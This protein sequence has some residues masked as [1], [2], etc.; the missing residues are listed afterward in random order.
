M[1]PSCLFDLWR[2][3][4]WCACA[5]PEGSLRRGSV[6]P[7][8]STPASLIPCVQKLSDQM[9]MR[10]IG[11]LCSFLFVVVAAVC[12]QGTFQY[13]NWLIRRTDFKIWLAYRRQD[14]W[15]QRTKS[16]GSEE[17]LK[18]WRWVESSCVSSIQTW[19]LCSLFI[20]RIANS[21]LPL[22][23]IVFNCSFVL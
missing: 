17:R 6:G 3:V 10:F 12:L 16:K 11:F 18:K 9:D 14:R 1:S 4:Y 20:L 2:I 13:I 19:I 7:S 21:T 23:S 22:F 5:R 8:Y 15:A